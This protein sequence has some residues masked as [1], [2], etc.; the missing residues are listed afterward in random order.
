MAPPQAASERQLK[1]RRSIDLAV[2]A[3]EDGLWEVDARLIDT[4]TRD[5]PLAGGVR[6]AGDPVHDMTLSLVI[7]TQMNILAA[8]AR[9]DWMPY[10]GHC[11]AYGDAYGRLVG[12]N[13]FRNFR[14]SV[15]E[16]L[17]GIQ[18]CTHL[19]ELCQVLPTAVVQAFA[20]E[21]LDTQESG[22]AQSDQQ[23]FQIDRCHALRSDG[24][25]VQTFYPRW[26]RPESAQ[27]GAG[28]SSSLTSP[29]DLS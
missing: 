25:A 17:G 10:P 5:Y 9:T 27:P 23:P 21:V 8:Q 4:K 28:S 15:K 7:D 14:Q 16:R 11:N 12:L 6:P 26:Y 18:G 19:T 2:Y 22:D 13:L 29:A 20:G 24:P 1:H 3:R